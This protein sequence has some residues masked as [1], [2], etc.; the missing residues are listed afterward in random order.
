LQPRLGP[1]PFTSGSALEFSFDK[2]FSVPHVPSN[3]NKKEDHEEQK[4]N[5]EA[6][7]NGNHSN[8]HGN[9]HE[10]EQE[11]EPMV[12]LREKT[13]VDEKPIVLSTTERR[14]VILFF[15]YLSFI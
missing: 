10:K 12:T 2:V 14:K 15:I 11:P 3:G 7:V 6:P 9:A 8:G 1:K 4:E 13:P 5:I